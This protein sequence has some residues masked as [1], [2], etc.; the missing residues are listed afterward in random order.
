M[1]FENILKT[2]LQGSKTRTSWEYKRTKRIQ[3][4]LSWERGTEERPKKYLVAVLSNDLEVFFLKPGKEVKRVRPNPHDMLPVVGT[5]DL[6]LKFDDVWSYLS[7]ISVADFESFKIVLT[8]IYRN[9]YFV[10]HVEKQDGKIRY[11]PR[12]EITNC[13]EQIDKEIGIVS[14][15]GLIGLL[16][17]LDILGWNEDMKYHVENNRP[18]FSGKYDL[19]VGRINTLLT[20]IRVPYQAALFVAHCIDRAN[21]KKSIDFS[22]LYTIMQQFAKSRGTC[23]PTKRQLAEWLSPYVDEKSSL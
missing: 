18:T 3:E 10:D 23:T 22:L 20:C 2:K 13:I 8:L 1:T 15:V 7:M 16:N 17:F 21:D 14:P 4:A 19:K 12:E 6:R 5:P 11:E 9:A